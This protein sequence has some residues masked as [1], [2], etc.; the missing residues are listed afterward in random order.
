MF[1]KCRLLQTGCIGLVLILL[2]PVASHGF[3]DIDQIR[4]E[5]E[6]ARLAKEKAEAERLRLAEE[7][8]PKFPANDEQISKSDRAGLSLSVLDPR[9]TSENEDK[10]RQLKTI[11]IDSPEAFFFQLTTGGI[12]AELEELARQQSIF[13][14]AQGRVVIDLTARTA[15]E[16]GDYVV[17]GKCYSVTDLFI[18]DRFIGKVGTSPRHDSKIRPLMVYLGKGVHTFR[19]RSRPFELAPRRPQ[20]YEIRLIPQ[21]PSQTPDAADQLKWFLPKGSR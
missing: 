18:N 16:A 20:T 10:A 17:T 13:G 12:G 11:A 4:A 6:Q 7:L 14:K 3:P 9:S 5:R 8:K 1:N 21:N 19:L 2:S 15:L